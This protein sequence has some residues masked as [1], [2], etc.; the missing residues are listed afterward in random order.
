M[1]H[2]DFILITGPNGF[3]AFLPVIPPVICFTGMGAP[4]SLFRPE[5]PDKFSNWSVLIRQVGGAPSFQPSRRPL[6]PI[7]PEYR[8]Q[9]EG[10][11]PVMAVILSS[12]GGYA[13]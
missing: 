4:G 5:C 6:R 8:L 2:L 10:P 12:P 7:L 1:F 11:S 13:G 3:P 9:A